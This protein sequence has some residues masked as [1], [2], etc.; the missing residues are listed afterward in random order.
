MKSLL[1]IALLSSGAYA[2]TIE[3]S[4]IKTAGGVRC[5]ER[6]IPSVTPSVYLQR[7]YINEQVV[8]AIIDR[9]DFRKVKRNLERKLSRGGYTYFYHNRKLGI[10]KNK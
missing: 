7:Q 5:E 1:L 9:K 4:C 6:L 10:V 8:Q 3:T 2:D